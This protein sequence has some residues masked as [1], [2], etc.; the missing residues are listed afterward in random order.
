MSYAVLAS[1]ENFVGTSLLLYASCMSAKSSKTISKY[2]NRLFHAHRLIPLR[3]ARG[4]EI[5]SYAHIAR[6]IENI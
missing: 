5:V 3:V 1:K 2:Q 4:V 6:A